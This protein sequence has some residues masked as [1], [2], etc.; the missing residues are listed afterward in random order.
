MI[1]VEFMLRKLYSSV[2]VAMSSLK[3][4][5]YKKTRLH[6]H[7]IL[8][9]GSDF[10]NQNIKILLYLSGKR[11]TTCLIHNFSFTIHNYRLSALQIRS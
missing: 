1:A 2:W 10:G 4:A 9:F 3:N 5:F 7:L 8:R 11:P 6:S